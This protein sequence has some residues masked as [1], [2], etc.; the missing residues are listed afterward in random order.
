[1]VPLQIPPEILILGIVSLFLIAVSVGL[2][3]W[4]YTDA[5]RRGDDNATLWATVVFVL[6]AMSLVGGPVAAGLYFVTRE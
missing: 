4:V 2:T 3:Y 5:T 1:M 6:S